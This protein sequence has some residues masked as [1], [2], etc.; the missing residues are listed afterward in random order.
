[1]LLSFVAGESINTGDAVTPHTSV[2]GSI[3]K[4]WPSGERT[5]AVCGVAMDMV[6]AGALTRVVSDSSVA[7]FSS[8]DIGEPYYVSPSGGTLVNY[9]QFRTEF[10]AYAGTAQV[11]GMYLCE[12]GTAIGSTMMKIQPA[13]PRLVQDDSV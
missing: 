6:T 8:L 9:A 7:V 5:S 12:V 3:L 4:A 11:S 13:M 10:L 2:S 1:M